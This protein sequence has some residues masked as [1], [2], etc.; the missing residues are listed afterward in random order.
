MFAKNIFRARFRQK[1]LKFLR[2]F[3]TDSTLPTAHCPLPTAFLNFDDHFLQTYLQDPF[4]YW[5]TAIAASYVT[6]A[7][8]SGS[9]KNFAGEFLAKTIENPD[10]FR[11]QVLLFHNFLPYC[12]M[13]S[14]PILV[15]RWNMTRQLHPVFSR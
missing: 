11:E 10:F 6:G 14:I 13:Y 15:R 3:E 9:Q 4:A 1:K 2:S 8:V 7:E 12:P 5:L